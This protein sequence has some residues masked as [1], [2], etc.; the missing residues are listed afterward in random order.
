MLL[1]RMR[2]KT[3]LAVKFDTDLL[4]RLDRFVEKQAFRITRTSAMETAVRQML[5][6]EE[7][8]ADRK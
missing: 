2:K 7:K 8:K 6:R 3:P 5:D 1:T 4:E